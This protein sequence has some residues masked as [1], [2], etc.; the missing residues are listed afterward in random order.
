MHALRTLAHH[1]AAITGLADPML[2]GGAG[3]TP[4]RRFRV[5]G[6]GIACLDAAVGTGWGLVPQWVRSEVSLC[7]EGRSGIPLWAFQS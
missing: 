1:R 3:I 5:F 4:T 2:D 6:M 7:S